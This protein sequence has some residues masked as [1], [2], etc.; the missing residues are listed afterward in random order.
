MALRCALQGGPWPCP[1]GRQRVVE[2]LL[3]MGPK[4]QCIALITAS[5]WHLG[6]H[7]GRSWGLLQAPPWLAGVAWSP[8][9]AERAPGSPG[10]ALGLGPCSPAT[11]LGHHC[12][13]AGPPL[14]VLG[15]RPQH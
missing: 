6:L 1:W 11:C 3:F 10:L 9:G 13:D 4:V 12:A 8:A 14:L 7:T 5:R 15:G 2:T